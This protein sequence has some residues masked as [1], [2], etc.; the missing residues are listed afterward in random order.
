MY[1]NYA[2]AQ[3]VWPQ[4][5]QPQQFKPNYPP[6]QQEYAPNANQLYQQQYNQSYQYTQPGYQQ[7]YN[8]PQPNPGQNPDNWDNWDWGWEES[9]KQ[10]QL[11]AQNAAP[12]QFNN[13]NV[14]EESFASTDTWNWSMEDKKEA[15]K[16]AVTESKPEPARPPQVEEVKLSDKDTV[17]ERAPNLALGK[18]FHTDNLTPQWSIESQMSQESSEGIHTHSESTFRSETQSRNSTKSSPGITTDATSFNFP[19]D[20]ALP[21][22]DWPTPTADEAQQMEQRKSHDDLTSS[23]QELSIANDEPA[24]QDR[25]T[26][27]HDEPSPSQSPSQPAMPPAPPVTAATLPPPTAPPPTAVLPPPT[28]FP[29]SNQNPFKNTGS[30]SHKATSNQP[31]SG[32]SGLTSPAAVNK[33]QHRPPVG[34]GANLE[35]TPDN[36]ERPDQPQ[37]AFRPIQVTQ[38]VPDNLEVAP[39]NDR[40]EYLQTAHL[41]TGDYGEN[42][43]FSRTMPP[44]PGLRRMVVGQQETEYGQASADEPPPGLARMVPGQPTEADNTYN[45][46]SDNYM[47]RLIDGQPTEDNSRPYRQAD[48]QQTPEHYTQPAQNRTERRP[49]GLDRMV[50]GEPSN[51]EYSQYQPGYSNEQRVVTGVDH[52][53][54]NAGPTDI[55]E[56]NVDGSDYTETTPRNPFGNVR[57]STNDVSSEYNG[58]PEEQQREVM[59]EGENLQDLSAIAPVDMTFTREQALDGADMNVSDIANDRKTDLSENDH[60]V[61]SS[62]RQSINRGTSGEES[63]RD[64]YKSSPRRD[65]DKHKSSRDKDRDRDRD[66]RYSRDSRGKH[67]SERR[68]RR[69][70]KERRRERGDSPE[71]RK[72][73]RGTRSHRYETED[74]DYYSDRERERR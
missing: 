60:P 40:N 48:G 51:D 39:Q 30:F 35:T 34:F 1:P 47:D 46:P 62:R 2:G 7:Y 73:R 22:I 53:Y 18:R 20:E 61:T 69:E 9:A 4:Q 66:G 23:L 65:R 68:V 28:N 8:Q 63:E 67:D 14:I 43:D 24:S 21:P 32:M 38:Q 52:D 56:Q 27:A 55:R 58:P 15:E 10:A 42:T 70:D 16:S 31:F 12:Q 33:V 54:P 37:V 45:Q 71:G 6:Y 3:P 50:P 74:T 19:H 57:G 41:S 17:K 5:P 13:A 26:N 29:P 64:R 44:P 11:A 72:P 49:V 25:D 36:S 59:M